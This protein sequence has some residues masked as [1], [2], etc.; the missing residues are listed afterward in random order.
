MQTHISTTPFGRRPMT[1]GMISS[2]ATARAVP[3][4]VIVHKWHVF[5]DIKDAR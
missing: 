3:K 1:L 5:Q 2:Q 4:D